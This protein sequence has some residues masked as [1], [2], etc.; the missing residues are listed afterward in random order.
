MPVDSLQKQEVSRLEPAHVRRTM[1]GL[2]PL[3]G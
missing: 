3:A 2:A 1:R